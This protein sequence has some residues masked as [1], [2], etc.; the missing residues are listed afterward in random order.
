[1]RL[2]VT[3]QKQTV[4]GF[5]GTLSIDTNP[6]TCFTVENLAHAIPEGT[7]TVKID[8]SPRLQIITPHIIVPARDQAAGGDAGI[9]IHSAN[10]PSQLL[11][12]IA[13]GDKQEVDAVDDSKETFL[14]LMAIINSVPDLT[15][16]II[17]II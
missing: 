14:K 16:Q 10:F 5:L 3:R 6:F 17:D 11:G 1:M 7:Y 12:C 15:I 8:L 9:R 13:V 4:D 2:T